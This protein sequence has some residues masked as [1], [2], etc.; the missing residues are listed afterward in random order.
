MKLSFKAGVA[1]FALCMAEAA[2]AQSRP[3]SLAALAPAAAVSEPRA[4]KLDGRALA[5]GGALAAPQAWAAYKQRFVTQSGR[6]V[7]TANGLISHSEGQGY[8]MLL[9]VAAND[10]AAFERIWGW[11]RANL[12]VRDDQLIAWRWTPGQRP[13]VS[14]MNNASDGDILVAWA[15][16][17][18]AELWADAAHRAAGRRIAVEIGRKLVLFKT[19]QG[20]VLLPGLAGFSAAERAD[21]PVINLSY[22]VF[23]A[24]ARLGVVA[25]ETDWA[26]LT[27]TGLD[28]IKAARFGASELPTDWI[29]LRDGAPRPADGFPAQFSYNAVRIPLYL[30][31]AGVGEWEH[32]RPFHAWAG[33]R[34][35]PSVVDVKT[36]REVERLSERGYASIGALLSCAIDKTP[37][38]GD[39]RLPRDGEHYYPATLHLMALVAMNM[40]YPTCL[41]G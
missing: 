25:P 8:G 33:G 30:A 15:L 31:W 22:Y 32:Y 4:M 16:A 10:R 35:Q 7:D 2:C 3:G 17:E 1:L 26:G 14:D 5:I 39:A 29:S 24:F 6:V 12:M 38:A 9:A 34:R 11:T 36:G 19:P 40:R 13:A 37:A 28:Q 23:P 21:G 18:A 20:A 41:K 27:Q